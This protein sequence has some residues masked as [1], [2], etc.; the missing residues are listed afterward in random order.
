MNS[1]KRFLLGLL[2]SLLLSAGLCKAAARLDPVRPTHIAATGLR[3]R[4]P[5]AI[6][7]DLPS[8]QD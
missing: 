2:S 1:L 8:L 7:C 3:L 6:P 5:C 4:S